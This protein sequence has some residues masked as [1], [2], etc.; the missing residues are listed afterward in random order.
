MNKLKI[1][2]FAL[3]AMIVFTGCS[4]KHGSDKDIMK[5]NDTVI[6]KE[7]FDKAFPEEFWA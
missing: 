4:F 1:A 3:I 7:E 5:I 6:T 2:V